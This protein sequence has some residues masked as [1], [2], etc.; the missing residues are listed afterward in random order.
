MQRYRHTFNRRFIYSE[1][2]KTVA[3][4]AGAYWLLDMVALEMVPIYVKAHDAGEAGT[5]IIHLTVPPRNDRAAHA[6]VSL[7]L[8]DDAPPAYARN[9]DYTDFPEGSWMF[10]LSRDLMADGSLLTTMIIPEEYR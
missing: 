10:F 3:T 7:S 4:T 6:V 9:L 8:D 2:V 1:G 5:G